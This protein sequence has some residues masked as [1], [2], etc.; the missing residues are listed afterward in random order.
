VLL[1]VYPNPFDG[2]ANV[3]FS[4]SRPGPAE[5]SV[6]DILGRKVALI[7]DGLFPAGPHRLTWDGRASGAPAAPG[8][9]FVRL[10]TPEVRLTQA[11]VLVRR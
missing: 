5:I 2:V 3:D 6:F 7:A 11:V 4:L 8:T 10:T 9:Y 1:P